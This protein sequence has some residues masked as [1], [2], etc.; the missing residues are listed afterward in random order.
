MPSILGKINQALSHGVTCLESQFT[1]KGV[2]RRIGLRV[3]K[4]KV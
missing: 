4:T 1:R 3:T 2:G